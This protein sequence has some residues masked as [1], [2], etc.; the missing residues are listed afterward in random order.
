MPQIFVDDIP[1]TVGAPAPTWGDLLA[2]LDEQVSSQGLLLATA[3]INGVEEPSFRD[4]A[5]TA[6]RL[7]DDDRVEVETA[8]P[9]AFLRQCLFDTVR[10]LDQAAETAARLSATYR[11]ADVSAAHDGLRALADELRGL[12]ALV[13]ML[14]GPLQI[15]L[16]AVVSN[17]MS[18]TEQIRE[19][20]SALDALVAAQAQQ[21]WLTVADVLEYDVEPAIHR[22]IELLTVI[23]N[24]L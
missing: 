2:T 1:Q 13:G 5:V 12:T 14:T 21:D 6:R 10:P 23:A 3:R 17:G 11:Q 20:G 22:W 9:S 18:A 7:A 24:R 15:D 16:D 8:T 19:F 4:P